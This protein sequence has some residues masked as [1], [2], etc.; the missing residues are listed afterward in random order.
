M[1]GTA[2]PGGTLALSC[3][4]GCAIDDGDSFIILD[5]TG[6]LTGTFSSVT[7]AGFGEGFTYGID[8]DATN[9]WVM[10]TV[11]DAGVMAPIP[12]PETYALLLAGLGLLGF[13][14]RRKVAISTVNQK[15]SA[16]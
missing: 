5:S 14:A 11:F 1:T 9:D 4:M 13:V 7:T 2:T 16:K 15:G 3:I 8:Y 6:N 10:L 12:E